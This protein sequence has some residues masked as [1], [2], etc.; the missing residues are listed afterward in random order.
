MTDDPLRFSGKGF[1][2]E[3]FT[4]DERASMRERHRHYDEHFID[5]SDLLELRPL[6]DIATLYKNRKLIL[7][8]VFVIMAFG[9]AI[10][11]AVERGLFQ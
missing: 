1:S 9:G 10:A 2:K 7:G 3:D 6:R 8:A 4:E 5:M 11:W